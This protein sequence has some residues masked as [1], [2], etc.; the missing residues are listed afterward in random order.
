MRV[1]SSTSFTSE[2]SSDVASAR[3]KKTTPRPLEVRLRYFSC[4]SRS[5]ADIFEAS[6]EER[7]SILPLAFAVSLAR[8]SAMA[9][10]AATNWSS[11]MR[12]FISSLR[13]VFSLNAKSGGLGA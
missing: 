1:A 4:F 12:F 6:T 8:R 3:G 13:S 11:D 9:L 7:K 2:D 10:V 5:A